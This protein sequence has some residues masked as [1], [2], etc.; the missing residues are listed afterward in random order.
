M[1][2]FKKLKSGWRYRLKYTDPFTQQ[3]REKS[4]RGFRTK[5]EA[6]LAAA[7]FLK[8]VK[9]GYEQSDVALVEYIQNWIDNYKKGVV[10]KNTI[11]QHMN[12]LNTH[13]KPYFKQ[14]MLKDLKP[15]MYQKF[16]DSCLGKGLSRRTVEIISSTVY[17]AIEHAIIQGKLER[18]PC[19][20]SVIKGERKK[21]SVEFI[22]SEDIPNFLHAARSYG[23]IYWIFFKVLLETGM[24]KG[25]A[26]ALKWSDINFEQKKIY[27]DETL[28]FQPEH[29]DEL[30]GDTKTQKS[31]RTIIVSTGLINDLIYHE[32][33][34]NQNKNTLG[35]SMYRHDLNLVLCKN[36]GNPMP[37][38][39]LFNASKRILKR[40]GLSED[41]HIHSLRHSYAVLML[42]AGAD[43][44]FIQE[45]LGH[46]SAKITYDVY[47]HISK[48]LEKRNID[49]YK[50]YTANILSS[51]NLKSGDVWGTPQ[52]K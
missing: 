22:D 51:T 46:E 33:W 35:E 15:D 17:G 49:K 20:G 21:E 48:K 26:A 10:R 28:D 52:K 6:E 16:L 19:K 5:P 34:Q 18:N 45:Q 47:A 13:I 24:R 2:N 36:D 42:E 8:N 27:I 23:Y 3:S 43:I 30:F 39:T 14:L 37:K 31:T 38:S 44:T 7:E 32:T 29:E 12:S 50:Q 1:A 9:Q 25:E 41:F 11:K 4:E 40:A